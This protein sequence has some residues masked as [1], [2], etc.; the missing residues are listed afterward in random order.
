M[1]KKMSRTV[2]ADKRSGD[3]DARLEQTLARAAAAHRAGA[4]DVA[5][6]SYREA[7]RLAPGTAEAWNN[8]GVALRAAGRPAE[9]RAA[10]RRALRA[11]PDYA[12]AHDNLGALLAAAGEHE[13]AVRHHLQAVRGAPDTPALLQRLAAAAA[14]LQPRRWDDALARALAHALGHPAVD[15]QPLAGVAARLLRLGPARTADGDALRDAL[16]R[17]AV[18][19]DDALEAELVAI[20]AAALA[21]WESAGPDGLD[22]RALAALALQA[23]TVEYAWPE[24]EAETAALGRLGGALAPGTEW[25]P[26]HLLWACYRPLDRLPSG[27]PPGA[28]PPLAAPLAER[29]IDAPAAERELGAALPALTPLGDPV[30]RA[31]AGQYDESPYP[32]WSRAPRRTPAPLGTVLRTLFPYA[33]GLDTTARRWSAPAPGPRILVAGCG[34]GR[35]A[36]D[37]ASRFAGATVLAVDLSRRALAYAARRAAAVG[38]EAV[39]FAQADI[40]ELGV[41]DDRFDLIESLGVLH[42]LD[43]PERGWRV[44]TGLLAPGGLMRIGLYTETGRRAVTAARA[45]V[46][47]HGLTPT[48]AGIRAARALIRALPEGHPARGVTASTDFYTASGCRDLVFHVREH[49]LALSDI[50]AMADRLGLAVIG[51]EHFNPAAHRLYRRRFPDDPAAADLRRWATLEAE[52]PA[53]FTAMAQFWCRPA[54]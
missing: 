15:P 32:R 42:H 53:L 49:A 8:L 33:P 51:V 50:A 20:R 31:V 22:A 52:H 14:P 45:L 44:L 1:V 28:P 5:I 47:G 25:G 24:T 19:D 36:I 9:A 54:S 34:T 4:L 38:A 35:H 10:Y 7:V 43:D 41:L 17:H 6:A 12:A 11:R 37:V 40:L 13:E 3:R 23:D 26:L 27:L 29:Q 46:A 39:R 16:L 30:S 18:V 48:P 21:A 2:A